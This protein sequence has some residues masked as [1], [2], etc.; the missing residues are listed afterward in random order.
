MATEV[1]N[2]GF[3]GFIGN[4]IPSG[5][6]LQ[7]ILLI[8][9]VVLVTFIIIGIVIWLV[10]NKLQWN[11]KIEGKLTRSDGNYIDAF[12]G[13]GSYSAKK[14][15]CYIKRPKFKKV[16]MKPFDIKEYLQGSNIL[17]VVQTGVD[18]YIPVHPSSWEKVID[19][20]YDKKGNKEEVEVA[21]MKLKADTTESKSWKN[22]YERE[23]KS[24][25]AVTNFLKEH[26]ALLAMGFVL[27][28]NLMGFVIL[29]SRIKPG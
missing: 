16:A 21:L 1:A 7:G 13:K 29:Y 22:S 14:G 28:M 20:Q 8:G 25:Y 24:A 4:M 9:L 15:V 23:A 2:Q 5:M 27:F 17:T 18:T 12:W 11:L 19:E 10:F 26:G 3:M 6:G